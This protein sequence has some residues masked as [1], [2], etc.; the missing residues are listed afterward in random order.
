MKRILDVATVLA[1]FAILGGYDFVRVVTG[2]LRQADNQRPSWLS[3]TVGAGVAA[4]KRMVADF[5]ARI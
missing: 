2:L 4:A 5:E 3:R 1:A